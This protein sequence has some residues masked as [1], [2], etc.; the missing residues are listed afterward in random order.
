MKLSWFRTARS[1]V[2]ALLAVAGALAADGAVAQAQS[3]VDVG[4]VAITGDPADPVTGGESRSFSVAGGD[5][6]NMLSAS[7][8]SEFG[9]HVSSAAGEEWQLTFAAPEGRTLEP[10]NY[11]AVDYASHGPRAGLSVVVDDRACT[12]LT[13]R[14]TVLAAS[15]RNGYI[16]RFDATFEQRCAGAQAAARGEIHIANRPLPDMGATTSSGKVDAA[17]TAYPAGAVTCEVPMQVAVLGTVTQTVQGRPVTGEFTVW[18]DCTPDAA[19]T[20][21]A[22]V[23]PQGSSHFVR[24]KAKVEL[25]AY[26]YLIE[27]DVTIDDRSKATVRLTRA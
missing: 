6:F 18:V 7:D 3:H 9:L 21:T 14:F 12:S 2:I 16:E 13:G 4:T 22:P 10:G 15:F 17:G 19:A 8:F 23:S 20:W 27:Q 24:G 26:A 11:R 1:A 5:W 25:A